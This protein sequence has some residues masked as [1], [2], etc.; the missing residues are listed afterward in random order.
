MTGPKTILAI[1]DDDSLRRVVEYNLIEEGYRVITAADGPSGLEA[2]QRQRFGAYSV[3][4]DDPA[5]P[6]VKGSQMRSRSAAGT[7]GP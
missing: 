5:R 6:R 2:Y 7:P 4:F 1:D 3:D